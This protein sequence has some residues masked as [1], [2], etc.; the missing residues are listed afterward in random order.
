MRLLFTVD[1][2]YALSV[3]EAMEKECGSVDAFLEK[4]LGLTA[5]KRK[6]LEAL[7]LEDI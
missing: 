4:E 3:F 1:E 2:A 6:R 5:E 7:Y